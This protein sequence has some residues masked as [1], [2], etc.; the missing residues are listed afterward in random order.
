MLNPNYRKDKSER[1]GKEILLDIK[2]DTRNLRN[3]RNTA[4]SNFE[5]IVVFDSD[6]IMIVD[7]ETD[8]LKK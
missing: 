7:K 5:E 8:Y 1:E 3:D 4:K 2:R 6:Q